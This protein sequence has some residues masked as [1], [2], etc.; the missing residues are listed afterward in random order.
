MGDSTTYIDLVRHGRVA[1]PGLFCAATD[2][3]LSAEGREQL[4]T[5]TAAAQADQ[6]ITS[7]SRRCYEFANQFAQAHA[8]PAQ[9]FNAFQEMNFGD[10]IGLAATE[11]WQRD[12]TLLQTLWASPLDFTAPNGEA[13][14]E[15]AERVEHSWHEL[16]AQHG[17]KRVLVFTHGGVIR[18]LLAM[19]LGI[20]YKN[21]M[22]FDLDYGSAVR[23]RVYE[24][25]AVSVYG[26][27]VRDLS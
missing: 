27:G 1:T 14:T 23:V 21:T 12:P 18:V 4:D 10:W 19:A 5:T 16:L 26:L 7:P 15:F 11:V 13:L 6:I 17:G 25:G 8:L 22:Q 3:P 24:D 2:E 20:P 9:T